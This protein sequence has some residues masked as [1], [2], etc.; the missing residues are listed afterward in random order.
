M[1]TGFNPWAGQIPRRRAQQPT[2]IFI[3]GESHG[4]RSLVG[5]DPRTEE[6]SGLRSV[7]SQRIRHDW[8][9]LSR[10]LGFTGDALWECTSQ[11]RRHGFS[12]GSGRALGVGEWQPTL[13]LCLENST[14]RGAWWAIV[15]GV[16]KSWI[17]LSMHYALGKTSTF[18]GSRA[19]SSCLLLKCECSL[20][21]HLC[22]P[23]SIL[24]ISM[25][26]VII[27]RFPSSQ[28]AISLPSVDLH[29]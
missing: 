9:Q 4:Q 6:P 11:C 24:T 2:P 26:S 16:A 22:S 23:H 7:E 1:R 8:S 20:G 27:W 28:H 21:L 19:G 15:H 18:S 3:L 5:Y 25:T 17:Q 13:V 10:H 12:L 29:I 14:D